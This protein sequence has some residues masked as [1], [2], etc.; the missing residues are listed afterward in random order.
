M[1][2]QRRKFV[3]L[4]LAL[5]VAGLCVAGCSRQPRLALVTGTV[6]LS[7]KPLEEVRVEFFPDP[8]EGNQAPMSAAE[9]DSEGKFS[10]VFQGSKQAPGAAIGMH[11]VV[12]WD[13]KS[14]NSRDNPI[15]PR[16]GSSFN[17]AR[18]TPVRVEVRD[19]EQVI[20]LELDKYQ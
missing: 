16:F 1:N 2:M 11:R 18:S 12:L 6:T 8:E 20:D 4:G 7:G 17:N 3:A 14:I 10:L 15:P 5:A 13:Y 19:G 9:T